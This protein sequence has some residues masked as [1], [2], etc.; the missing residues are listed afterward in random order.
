V[1]TKTDVHITAASVFNLTT[2]T[3]CVDQWDRAVQRSVAWNHISGCDQV[4]IIP[5]ITRQ[6]AR[7]ACRRS[8][9]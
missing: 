6:R 4:P 3:V 5:C 8:A 1:Y 7:P 2:N 9:C